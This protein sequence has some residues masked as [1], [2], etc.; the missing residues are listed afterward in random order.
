MHGLVAAAAH[1]LALVAADVDGVVELHQLVPVALGAQEHL[2]AAALVLEAQLVV[3][4]AAG[5][6]V[7]AQAAAGGVLGE[8]EGLRGDGVGEAADDHRLVG[9]ALVV[10]HQHLHADAGDELGAPRRPRP[11]V[12]HADPARAVLVLLAHPVPVELHLDAAL[13]VRV[14]L[15]ALGADD[16]GRVGH[17]HRARRR[18]ARADGQLGRRCGEGVVVLHRL[19]AAVALG[20]GHLGGDAAVA[21]A[22]DHPHAV[23]PLLFVVGEREL[24]PGREPAAQALALGLPGAAPVLLQLELGVGVLGV[25]LEEVRVVAV[26]LALLQIG[27]HARDQVEGRGAD[28]PAPAAAQRRPHVVEGRAAERAGRALHVA[29]RARRAL[30]VE[31]GALVE[32][33]A[34][35]HRVGAERA[36]QAHP[37]H[38]RLDLDGQAERIAVHQRG[39]RG[40]QVG[41]HRVADGARHALHELGGLAVG[42]GGVE[43]RLIAHHQRLH[44]AQRARHAAPDE[45]GHGAQ[46]RAQRAEPALL[47]DAHG[48][49]EVEVAGRLREQA[50]DEGEVALLVLDAIGAL[51]QRRGEVEAHG[52]PGLAHHG[53]DHVLR[54]LVLEDAG[55]DP[56]AQLPDGGHEAQRVAPRG[57]LA[58]PGALGAQPGADAVHDPR[59][60]AGSLHHQRGRLPEEPRL[61]LPRRRVAAEED[62]EGEQ[63]GERLAALE[64]EHLELALHEGPGAQLEQRGLGARGGGFEARRDRGGHVTG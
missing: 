58:L 31:E 9:V 62:L 35:H 54:R 23:H 30:G 17:L 26:H 33:V 51:R 38:G 39:R 49:L 55:V 42:D 20:A 25:E 29:E 3:P 37:G 45:A 10:E 18:A 40:G 13:G 32:V 16:H 61:Q 8:R 1:R 57:V 59:R 7:G 48:G 36:P 4:A 15:L 52:H 11:R 5:Q 2:L 22:G 12:Q 24:V 53:A 14:D 43:A 64:L 21:H 6:R 47:E 46:A 63:L 60:V 44:Q 27:R 41:D 56:L 34:Q 50:R 28:A 19:L